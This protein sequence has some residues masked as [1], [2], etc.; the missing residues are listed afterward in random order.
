MVLR[1]MVE[2]Q[3]TRQPHKA[4][5]ARDH[6]RGLPSPTEV[7]RQNPEWSEGA[8]ERRTTVEQRRREPTF[9]SR[10]PF[11]D[12][13]RRGRPIR[14]FRRTQQKP[15]SHETQKATRQ[16]GCDRY[17]RITCHGQAK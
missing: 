2:N 17:H 9:A 14:G 12:G 7:D 6:E 16:R 8:S 10:K 1:P 11:R 13:F 3:P 5:Y 15:K 4:E